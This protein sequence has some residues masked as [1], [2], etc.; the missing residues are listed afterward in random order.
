MQWKA[1]TRDRGQ[2]I[3][4]PA[5]RWAGWIALGLLAL[6][7][8]LSTSPAAAQDLAEVFRG[9]LLEAVGLLGEVVETDPEL[10]ESGRIQRLEKEIL[11]AGA[12]SLRP[13]A[14]AV[15]A[16][17]VWRSSVDRLRRAADE[18][19]QTEAAADPGTTEGG[20][21]PPYSS[22]CG[23]DRPST[24]SLFIGLLLTNLFEG[25]EIAGQ[26][27]CDVATSGDLNALNV[28][29]CGVT[30]VLGEARLLAQSSYESNSLCSADVDSAEINAAYRLSDQI[31][32]V[33]EDNLDEQVSTRASQDSLDDHAADVDVQLVRMQNDVSGLV[34]GVANVQAELDNVQAELDD[35]Q[36]RVTDTQ[37]GVED[38]ETRVGDIEQSVDDL[39][40]EVQNLADT[41]SGLAATLDDFIDSSQSFN[42]LNLQILIEDDLE[43]KGTAAVSLFQLPASV[44]GYLELVREIVITTIEA[45]QAAGQSVGSAFKSVAEGDLLFDAGAY[46]DAYLL[47]RDAYHQATGRSAS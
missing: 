16:D 27:V 1:T 18:L 34:S 40:I 37:L 33:V 12:E 25:L 10:A 23:D 5:E 8:L 19:Y 7:G 21:S 15:A 17:G 44:G 22:N 14:A 43:R 11:T 9:E 29:V 46:R 6:V 13:L 45:N 30:A 39:R 20:I 24:Q 3:R 38:L 32:G 26:S 35:V 42:A 2:R 41:T 47:Y 31:D 28:V 4:E 36:V